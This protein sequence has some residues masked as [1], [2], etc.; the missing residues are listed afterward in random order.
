MRPYKPHDRVAHRHS[1]RIDEVDGVPTTHTQHGWHHAWTVTDGPN[2]A[3]PR[4]FV[5]KKS[6]PAKVAVPVMCALVLTAMTVAL[7]TA[8]DGHPD[9]TPVILASFAAV[10]A[11]TLVLMLPAFTRAA[12]RTGQAQSANPVAATDP[13]RVAAQAGHGQASN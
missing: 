2:A 13:D 11:W 7:I 3:A 10:A 9:T 5:A 12:A 4:P 6:V 1:R 8:L